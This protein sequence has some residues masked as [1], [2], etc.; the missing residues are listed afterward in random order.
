[1]L[2]GG[3]WEQTFLGIIELPN[4]LNK[5]EIKIKTS[6]KH[7]SACHRGRCLPT[8]LYLVKTTFCLNIV[9]LVSYEREWPVDSKNDNHF[10]CRI[11]GSKVI[12]QNIRF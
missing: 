12:D 11:Y 7:F 5:R 2:G 6:Q 3:T 4:G 1:M 9:K 10:D 8:F